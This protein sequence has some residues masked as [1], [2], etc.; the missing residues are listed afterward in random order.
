MQGLLSAQ[1]AFLNSIVGWVGRFTREWKIACLRSRW[2]CPGIM[3]DLATR[4]PIL[5]DEILIQ[6]RLRDPGGRWWIHKTGS[7][8]ATGI[9]RN[10]VGANSPEHTRAHSPHCTQLLNISATVAKSPKLAYHILFMGLIPCGHT[11]G[12]ISQFWQVVT[13][14]YKSNRACLWLETSATL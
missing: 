4:H 3:L 9:Q 2:C 11:C 13:S 10:E 6:F 12:Y 8:H 14:G 7:L 5:F 1:L